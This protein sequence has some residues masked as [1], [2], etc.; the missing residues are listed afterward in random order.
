MDVMI[1]IEMMGE[2]PEAAI[3]AIAA[4][5]FERLGGEDPTWDRALA[6][7]WQ[8]AVAVQSAQNAG[9]NVSGKT[10]SWWLGQSDVARA[11][12]LESPQ[13]LREALS[14]LRKRLLNAAGGGNKNLVVW[15][16]PAAADFV[17]LES[18][19]RLTGSQEPWLGRNRRCLSTLRHELRGI[20]WP[21]DRQ[22]KS[23]AHIALYDVWLQILDARAACAALARLGGDR[24]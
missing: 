13:P 15:A 18:A 21:S 2:G 5:P 9:M 20:D 16:K 1:D 12:L 22:D 23:N 7:G 4:C 17:V 3:C 6:D 14:E 10:I 24:T 19:Y 8:T 11:A